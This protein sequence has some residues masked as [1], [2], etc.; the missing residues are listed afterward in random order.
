MEV[1]AEGYGDW[2]LRD[3]REQD[4]SPDARLFVARSDYFANARSAH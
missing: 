4:L 1:F 2:C 3:A